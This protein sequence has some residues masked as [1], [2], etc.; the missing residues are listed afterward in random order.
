MDQSHL[1]EEEEDLVKKG[2]LMRQRLQ[3]KMKKNMIIKKTPGI[4]QLA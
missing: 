4:S 3:A 2:I 1:V